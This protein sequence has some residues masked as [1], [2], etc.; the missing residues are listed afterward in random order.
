[1]RRASHLRRGD[2]DTLLKLTNALF[3]RQLTPKGPVLEAVKGPLRMGGELVVRIVVRVDRDMEYVHLKDHR[4]SGTE[5]VNVLS[6]FKFQ[7][8]LGYCGTTRDTA[9]HFFFE[10]L[11]KGNYV[12]EYATRI[13][14]CGRCH[15]GFANIECMYAPEFGGHSE[16]LWVEAEQ[17]CILR[18][19]A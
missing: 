17:G 15:T 5:P 14:H 8:G 1:M 13:V 16:S 10:H 9:S 18:C 2:E 3:T 19:R 7:D 11:P 6:Q 12:F 4:G